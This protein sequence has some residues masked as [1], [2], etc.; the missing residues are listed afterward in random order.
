MYVCVCHTVGLD[1]A[2]GDGETVQGRKTVYFLSS[3]FAAKVAANN[4]TTFR[5]AA[6][7]GSQPQLGSWNS[8]FCS[9]LLSFNQT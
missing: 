6:R 1:L 2:N 8:F 9:L 4:M 3:N 5:K 7:L